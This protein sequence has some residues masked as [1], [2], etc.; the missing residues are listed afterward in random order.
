[1]VSE[2]HKLSCYDEEISTIQQVLD[3]LVTARSALQVYA[4]KCQ[5]VFAPIRRLSS[6]M[7]LEIFSMYTASFNDTML[8]WDSPMAQEHLHRLAK[9]HLLN[10]LQVCSTWHTL[11]IGTPALW[12][13]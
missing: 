5:S 2:P 3:Q 13:V 11:V 10:L 9:P 8:S 4:D 12:V 7:L 1:I 6:D